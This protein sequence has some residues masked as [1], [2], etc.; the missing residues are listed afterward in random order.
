VFELYSNAVCPA[1][2][3]ERFENF[4]YIALA[5]CGIWLYFLFTHAPTPLTH[6]TPLHTHTPHTRLLHFLYP[7]HTLAHNQHT[8]FFVHTRTHSH[9]HTQ[10][11]ALTRANRHVWRASAGISVCCCPLC[12]CALRSLFYYGRGTT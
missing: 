11:H 7:Q 9:V 3:L 2:T 10:T 5:Y 12:V 6:L 8:H 4:I 1:N